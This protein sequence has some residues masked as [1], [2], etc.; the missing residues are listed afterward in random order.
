MLQ[1]MRA[2]AIVVVG[3]FVLAACG[4]AERQI[5]TAGGLD[6]AGAGG[7]NGGGSANTSGSANAGAPSGSAGAPQGSAGAPSGSA[8]APQGSAGAPQGSAG[9][10]QG[11]AGAA[12]VSC[13]WAHFTTDSKNEKGIGAACGGLSQAAEAAACGSNFCLSRVLADRWP[14]WDLEPKFGHCTKHCQSNSECGTGFQCCEVRSGAFCLVYE[15]SLLLGSGCAER[16]ATNH[17]ACS[18]GEICCERLG[19]VCVSDRCDGICPQ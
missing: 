19:R 10:P 11:N 13:E 4:K 8:G 17:L 9:A 16:C 18:E 1:M 12:P 6:D 5:Q 3:S 7:V 14:T 15:E 2:F